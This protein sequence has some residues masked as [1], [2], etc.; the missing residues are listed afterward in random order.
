MK[1]VHSILV[2]EDDRHVRETLS[3]FLEEQEYEV[4]AVLDAEEALEK[5]KGK[6]YDVI[7][8]D[9]NLPGISGMELIPLCREISP[10]TDIIVM[11]GFGTIDT[12][13]DCIRKGAIRYIMKPLNP[14]QVLYTIRIVF[15]LRKFGERE[16]SESR[17]EKP[18]SSF[19]DLIGKSISMQ[20]NYEVIRTIAPLDVPVLVTGESGTGKELVARAIHAKSGRKEGR[21]VAVNCGALSESLLLSELFGHVKGAFTGAVADKKGLFHEAE[22]GTIFLDEIGEASQALQV[23]LLR[24]LEEGVFRRIGAAGTDTADFR[25]IAATN[26]SLTE[27]MEK[28]LFRQDLF[29]RLNVVYI[30]IPPLRARREDIPLLVTHFLR[31]I[32]LRQGKKVNGISS[33]AMSLLMGFDW[34]GNVR[35]LEN[36]I[37]GSVAFCKEEI[38]RVEDL[39]AKLRKRNRGR[40]P[41]IDE[42]GV[43][44]LEEARKRTESA[45]IR[46][47]LEKTGWNK[48]EAARL[49]Q[50]DTATLWRKAKAY[51]IEKPL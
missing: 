3:K 48:K 18:E 38:V 5:I 19:L 35:E 25:V 14:E 22:G 7:I 34:P 41:I 42:D 39:P 16:I 15:A 6:R 17:E 27:N 21:F 33:E 43:V 13:I 51:G 44:P 49:L 45:C 8:T 20:R 11:S 29:Y 2:V 32:S 9:L 40:A 26:R 30:S 24:V 31:K 36:A 47:A 4:S 12:A 37:E 28:G 1:Q 46:R 50:V 23:G 10:K